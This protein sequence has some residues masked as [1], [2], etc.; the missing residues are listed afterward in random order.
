MALPPLA[1]RELILSRT[2][3]SKKKTTKKTLQGLM[4][5]SQRE[6]KETLD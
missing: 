5:M 6:H 2:E 4:L 1:H 3:N